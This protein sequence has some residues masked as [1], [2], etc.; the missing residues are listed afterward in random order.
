MASGWSPSSRRVWVEI[1]CDYKVMR[2]VAKVTLLAEGVGRNAKDSVTAPNVATSPSS[3]RVW[4]EIQTLFADLVKLIVSP[5]SRRVWVEI[6]FLI[7]LLHDV[8][9]TLLAEGVGRNRYVLDNEGYPYRH[10]PRGGCG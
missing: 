4:V 2:A 10:P 5:S 3:R 9:V 7:G 8:C 6:P 1:V